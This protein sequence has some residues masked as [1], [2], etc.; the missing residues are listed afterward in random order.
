[1]LRRFLL[2]LFT[3]AVLIGDFAAEKPIPGGH[4]SSDSEK[5]SRCSILSSTKQDFGF[6][7]GGLPLTWLEK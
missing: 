6:A 7:T 4:S 3:F 5:R 1:M 2:G